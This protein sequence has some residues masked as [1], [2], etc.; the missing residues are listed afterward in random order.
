MKR[1]AIL[2]ALL[3]A[4]AAQYLVLLRPWYQSWGATYAEMQAGLPGDALAPDAAQ[5]ETRAITIG[6][7]PEKVWPWL[8]QLG[9]DRAGFYGY[10]LLQALFGAPMP[11]GD[12]LLG[13]P[14]PRPGDRLLMAPR[15]SMGGRAYAVY[16][17][18]VPGEALVLRTYALAALGHDGAPPPRGSWAFVL[19]PTEGGRATRLLVRSRTGAEQAPPSLAGA[20]L[21]ALVLDPVHFAFERALLLGVKARAEGRPLTPPWEEALEAA[22]WLVTVALGAAAARSEPS[23]SRYLAA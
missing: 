6:A 5:Q 12:R 15:P 17:A 18:V 9:Q 22:L 8:A 2:G 3:A 20:A 23:W 10:G 21:G 11:R 1:F 16:E 7:P 4:L 14:D 19:R 13:L